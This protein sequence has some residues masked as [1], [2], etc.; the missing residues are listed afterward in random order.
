[1]KQRRKQRVGRIYTIVVFSL[2]ALAFAWIV[3]RRFLT[4]PTVKPALGDWYMVVPPL[5]GD[6]AGIAIDPSAPLSQ[7][8]VKGSFATAPACKRPSSGTSYRLAASRYM[9]AGMMIVAPRAGH[10]FSPLDAS[11]PI[12]WAS[13]RLALRIASLDIAGPAGETQH[14]Q[15]ERMREEIR[16]Q[17]NGLEERM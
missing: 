1:M 13:V 11:A 5:T 7:W 16:V 15:Y 2:M 8:K 14:Q 10:R 9:A 17:T 3:I 4:G 6:S 12:A